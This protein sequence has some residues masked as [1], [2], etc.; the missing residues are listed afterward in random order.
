[1]Q[2]LRL[3]YD[4]ARTCALPASARPPAVMLSPTRTL[5]LRRGSEGTAH[6]PAFQRQ[7]YTSRMF[8]VQ[9]PESALKG[10]GHP[11]PTAEIEF[12]ASKSTNLNLINDQ[13]NSEPVRKVMKVLEVTKSTYFP[14]FNRLCK[15]VAQARMEV[16]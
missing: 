6:S 5:R 1:M 12:W 8:S 14:A 3:E 15:E 9:D 11:G 16:P 10:D 13:L 4:H 7:H 2:F